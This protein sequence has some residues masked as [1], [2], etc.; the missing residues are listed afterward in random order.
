MTQKKAQKPSCRP[1]FN[2]TIQYKTRQFSK[3]KAE[4]VKLTLNSGKTTYTY[5]IK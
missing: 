4:F 3:L 5:E 2:M 1:S